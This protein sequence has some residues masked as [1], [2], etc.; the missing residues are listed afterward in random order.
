[1]SNAPPRAPG[2]LAEIEAKLKMIADHGHACASFNSAE[3]AVILASLRS[4][5][6]DGGEA[7]RE[8]CAVECEE[9]SNERW[10]YTEKFVIKGLHDKAAIESGA[11]GGARECAERIR[12]LPLQPRSTKIEGAGDNG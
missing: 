2:E 12:A 8:A 6:G 7:M 11:V 1:M 9:V 4:A 5:T 10:G 3:C